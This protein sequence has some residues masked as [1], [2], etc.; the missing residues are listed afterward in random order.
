M[1]IQS[2][3]AIDK[4]PTKVKES[5]QV[6]LGIKSTHGVALPVD[7]LDSVRIDLGCGAKKRDDFSWI[8]IDVYPYPCVDI[9]R[10]VEKQGFPL[11]DCCVDVVYA[12]HFMEHTGNM[13]FVMDE[14]WRVLK[15]GGVLEMINPWWESVYAFAHPDHKRVIH[16]AIWGWWQVGCIDNADRKGYGAKAVFRML[17]N[18]HEGDGLFTVLLAVK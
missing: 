5:I 3:L 6:R 16:P 7:H 2:R 13:I 18:E 12:S 4:L 9:V 14:I 15:R 17:S 8:G 1:S 11:C 10:D